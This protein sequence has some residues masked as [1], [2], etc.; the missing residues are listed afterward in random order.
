VERLV[1]QVERASPAVVE[2]MQPQG[3]GTPQATFVSHHIVLAGRARGH[4]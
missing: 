3:F 2:W 4:P 1:E